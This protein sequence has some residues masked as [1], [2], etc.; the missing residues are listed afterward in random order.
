MN[1]AHFHLMFN[2]LSI[3]G[4]GFAILFNLV[5]IIR[6]NEEL[7]RLSCWFYILIGLLSVLAIFTGDGAGEIVK[8]YPGVSNDAIEYHETWGYIFFYG[9]IAVGAGSLAALWFSRKN[10]ILLKKINIAALILSIVLL[11]FAYQVGTTG[12]KI[13]HPEIEQGDL[14]KN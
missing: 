4:L 14:K 13:R 2:H 7:I 12:G 3:V 11:V 9:L 6:K 5:A 8:T 10:G 1:A